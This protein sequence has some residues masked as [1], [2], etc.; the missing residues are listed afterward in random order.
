[1]GKVADV[2]H[3]SKLLAR[4]QEAVR[5]LEQRRHSITH[6]YQEPSLRSTEQHP[7]VVMI[8]SLVPKIERRSAYIPVAVVDGEQEPAGQAGQTRLRAESGIQVRYQRS[9]IGRTA[10]DACQRRTE[11]VAN[12]LVRLR[13]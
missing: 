5:K 7:P 1:M 11:D 10:T 12:Q 2:P 3:V 6:W 9:N 4:R 13:W 8:Y